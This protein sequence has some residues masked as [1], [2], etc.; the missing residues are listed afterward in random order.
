MAAA[1]GRLPS[2]RPLHSPTLKRLQPAVMALSIPSAVPAWCLQLLSLVTRTAK[3][4]GAAI[5]AHRV[6]RSANGCL[7]ALPRTGVDPV[8]VVRPYQSC[9]GCRYSSGRFHR[10]QQGIAPRPCVV[11]I[12]GGGSNSRFSHL[13]SR[14][15]IQS[16]MVSISCGSALGMLRSLSARCALLRRS[17]LCVI[18]FGTSMQRVVLPC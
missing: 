13:S 17:Q 12:A 15:F 11:G 1:V 18:E 9:V 4:V 8:S 14:I 6:A 5:P 10:A 16:S 3:W 2:H 7:R